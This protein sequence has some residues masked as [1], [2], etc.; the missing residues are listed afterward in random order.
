M[1]SFSKIFI[2]SWIFFLLEKNWTIYFIQNHFINGYFFIV[3]HSKMFSPKN[4]TMLFHLKKIKKMILKYLN[5]D[6]YRR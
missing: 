3:F 6:Q 1:T 2:D 4:K 5:Q